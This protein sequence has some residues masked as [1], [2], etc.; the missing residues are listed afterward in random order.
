MEADVLARGYPFFSFMTE[1]IEQYLPPET[2]ETREKLRGKMCFKA[3]VG[4]IDTLASGTPE[5]V[6]K[7]ADVLAENF[8]TPSGGFVCEIVKWHRP[9]YP[10]S[11]VNASIKAFNKYRKNAPQY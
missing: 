1:F 10:D 8:H 9:A 5:E 3:T 6:E 7:E 4:M 11:T 2:K